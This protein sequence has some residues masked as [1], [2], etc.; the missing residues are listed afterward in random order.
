MQNINYMAH[1]LVYSI[2]HVQLCILQHI[3]VLLNHSINA[4]VKLLQT[5][6]HTDQGHCK[7]GI[8]LQLCRP[9]GNDWRW[10]TRCGSY[11]HYTPFYCLL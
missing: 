5:G 11:R 7:A 6:V 9:R 4:T 1:L 8:A 2:F 10:F 3:L